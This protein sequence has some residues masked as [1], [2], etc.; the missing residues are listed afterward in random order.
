[1][2]RRSADT[3]NLESAKRAARNPP[4]VT[5][6]VPARNEEIAIERSIRSILAQDHPNL[7]VVAVNDRS[8]DRTAQIL[9]K[10][11]DPRLTV[12]ETPEL[13]D[14]WMGKCHA[15]YCGVN[16]APVKSDY[17]L[18]TDADVIYAPETVR[19]AASHIARA[20]SDLLVLFP[21]IDCVGFWENAILPIL[22]HL[23]FIG[24]DPK[25]IVDPD[26][27]DFIGIG[28]F[29]LIRREMYERW[30]GHEAIRNE[31]IDDMAMGLKTK[32]E[33]G[34]IVITRDFDAIHLRWYNS[35]G[36]IV[37]GFE[38]NMHQAVGHGIPGAVAS[39]IFFPLFHAM[40][41][42]IAIGFLIA[43]PT[44]WFVWAPAFL[45][46]FETGMKLV[47]RMRIAFSFKPLI[48]AFAYP[49]GAFLAAVIMLRSAYFSEI[50]R[51]IRWRDRS[52][53]RGKQ[54]TRLVR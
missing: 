42:L 13:P 45:L 30:G 47:G 40:P 2:R 39:A 24:M 15:L 10:F 35:L 27:K 18:F 48:V 49:L 50:K 20:K 9:R 46:Y 26:R 7:H 16:A 5:V 34:R 22:S 36:G 25:K 12:I 29:G 23:G 19:R 4:S 28:A 6:F 52:L 11:S 32:Q 1:Y 44:A 33:R 14:G 31:V 37:R 8:T 43:K 21:R 41:L 54:E 3:P 38:K 17:Y 51:E 53:P